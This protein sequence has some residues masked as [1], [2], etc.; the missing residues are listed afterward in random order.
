MA[1]KRRKWPR[2]IGDR[3]LNRVKYC[4]IIADNLSKTGGSWGARLSD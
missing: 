4:E 1:D 2:T 3:S